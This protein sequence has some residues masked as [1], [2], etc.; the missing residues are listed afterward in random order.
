MTGTTLHRTRG[1]C[2]L[3]ALLAFG[4]G[5]AACGSSPSATSTT[6][7][8]TSS[9]GSTGSA[10]NTGSAADNL[11]SLT[12]L[13][14]AGKSATFEA[15]YTYKSS[16]KT[17]TIT[18]AQ[19][20]PKSLF[21]VGTTGQIINDGTKTYVCGAGTCYASSTTADPLVSLTYLFDG[22]TFLDSVAAYSATAAA[23]AAQ[24]ITLTYSTSSYAGQSSKCVTVHSSK[25][26]TKTFTWCVASNG[27]M[28][29]WN[30]G[31]SS[32][33]LTSFSTSPPA[34]DFQVPSSYKVL[35]TP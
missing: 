22:Q 29:S 17:E 14:T 21:K 16:G 7:T 35:G 10:G 13:A 30:S 12:S 2:A 32:F 31:K 15:V 3:A 24:G 20:P 18:F 5:L 11:S 1:L 27:I 4:V 25:S 19:A 23:L 9:T 28:T 33:T 34:S 8:T 6:T 26:T